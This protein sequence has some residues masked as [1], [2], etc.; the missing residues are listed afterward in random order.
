MLFK[1]Q[2][3]EKKTDVSLFAVCLHQARQLIVMRDVYSVLAGEYVCVL[4]D[5]QQTHFSCIG[6][7]NC[8]VTVHAMISRVYLSSLAE[9]WVEELVFSVCFL[10]LVRGH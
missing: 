2:C 3:G 5:M 4:I 1:L 6:G 10:V 8:H 9:L 7:K